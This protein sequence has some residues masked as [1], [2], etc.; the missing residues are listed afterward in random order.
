VQTDELIRGIVADLP[1]PTGSVAKILTICLLL[2]LTFSFAIMFLWLGPRPELSEA[3]RSAPFWIKAGYTFM[4][5]TAGLFAIERLGRPGATAVS[6]FTILGVTI[7]VLALS[8][9]AEIAMAP[10]SER[11]EIWL[12]NSSSIC[13]WMIAVLS[14]P[15][16]VG[17]FLS[18]RRLA[19]T[20]YATAGAAAGI[21]AGG[22]GA[23]I[24]SLHCTEYALSFLATWYTFGVLL[25]AGLGAL[26]S[27]FLRW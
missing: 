4:I 25:V 23:C 24:Y 14:L 13:P 21:M 11:H 3:L 26:F 16:L 1:T 17:A 8:A 12:G 2:S 19:P 20:H 10:P 5:G 15:L 18:L 7:A 27:R 22:Y 6:S 9:G